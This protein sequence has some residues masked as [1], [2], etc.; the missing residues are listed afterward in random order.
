MSGSEERPS[1]GERMAEAVASADQATTTNLR[2]A[3]AAAAEAV[4][5][6]ASKVVDGVVGAAAVAGG[7]AKSAME[8]GVVS[9]WVSGDEGPS[10]W[11]QPAIG[12]SEG[13]HAT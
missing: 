6:G 10:L 7:V 8:V 1:V 3:T 2:D 9:G 11:L 5:Q 12:E 4:G 13:S